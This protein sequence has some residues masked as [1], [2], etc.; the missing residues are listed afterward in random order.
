MVTNNVKWIYDT[1]ASRHFSTNKELMQD[2]KEAYGECIYMGNSTVARAMGK[3]KIL[4][5]LTSSK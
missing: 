1:G 2:F 5:K 4:L 3:G